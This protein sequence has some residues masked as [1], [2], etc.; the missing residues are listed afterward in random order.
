MRMEAVSGE[1]DD[2]DFDDGAV[3]RVFG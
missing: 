3:N 1:D 2:E